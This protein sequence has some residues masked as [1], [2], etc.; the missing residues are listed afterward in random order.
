MKINFKQP[1][2]VLPL[3]ILP[4][5]CL[6]FYV[7]HS[8]AGKSGK[9]M[10]EQKGLKATVADVSPEVRKK[11]LADKLDAYRNTYKEADGRSAVTLIPTGSGDQQHQPVRDAD[12]AKKKLD[13]IDQVMKV[14]FSRPR[15]PASDEAV[16]KAI[17]QVNS[18]RKT[19]TEHFEAPVKEKDP[20]DMFRQQ[21]AYIDSFQKQ[22]D[23]GFKA[24]KLKQ[25]KAAQALRDKAAEVKLPVSKADASSD[26]FNTVKPQKDDPFISAVVDENITGYAGSRLRLRLLDD[27]RAGNF[28]IPRGTFIYAEINGFS[29]QRVTLKVTS[30]LSGGKILPVKLD[31]YDLDGMPGLYVPA[32]AFRDFTKDLGSNSVQGISIDNASGSFVMSTMGRMFQSTSSAIADMIRKNKAKLKFNTYIYL[33][34]TDA[35]QNAQKK[36]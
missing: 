23:P 26:D 25:E 17:N 4:F 6:F 14:R 31:I 5:L 33:I 3:I 35:L 29:G 32:S 12:N 11:Q 7:W 30:I 18:S 34:D 20:M 24:E 36:Y 22:K 8:S 2:Y 9:D 21:L 15:K 1:R 19:K 10:K 13:S 27:I 16:A 28:V